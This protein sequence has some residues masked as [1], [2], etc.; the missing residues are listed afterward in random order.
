MRAYRPQS[1]DCRLQTIDKKNLCSVFFTLGSDNEHGGNV[2]KLA[3]ELGVSE[4]EIIDFSA[5]VNPLGVSRKVKAEIRKE[6][7]SLHNYPDPDTKK[8]RE[9]IAE[10]HNISPDTILCGNGSTELIYLIPRALK[11]QRILIPQPT[12][13]EYERA[14]KMSDE[15]R[16]KSYELKRENNFDINPDDFILSLVTRHS[17]LP[18]DMVFLCNPNNPTGRLLKKDDVLK[19][20]EASRKLKCYLVVDEAFIDFCPG[21][22]AI[23]YV[24]DNPYLIVLRSMTKFHALTSLRIGYGVFPSHL[25]NRLKEFKEPWTV[26]NL[27]QKAGIVAIKDNEYAD[28]TFRLIRREK[29]F[30]ESSFIKLGIDF[31]P[32]DA[33]FYLLKIKDNTKVDLKL[34]GK[35]ILVRNCSNFRGLDSSHIRVAVRSHKDNVILIRELS[36]LQNSSTQRSICVKGQS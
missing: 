18:F 28:K 16:V 13:S 12:F 4:R 15:L 8:L 36:R 24:Q 9:T 22:S 34:R 30:L 32:S 26:N 3:E 11:P 17:S 29:D 14:C 25:I 5:S 6:L 20:A 23:K 2:Y 35:G 31:Y 21:E 7:R 33:N 19:I 1:T 27:A 10:R